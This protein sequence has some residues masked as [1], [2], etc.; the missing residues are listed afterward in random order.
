[1]NAA[2]GSSSFRAILSSGRFQYGAEVVT[3]RGWQPPGTP[4]KIAAFAADLLAEPRVGWISITDNA[5]GGPMLPPD[6]LAAHVAPE[7]HRVVIHLTCKDM[8]R[9]ALEAALW[10]YASEGFENILALTGDYPTGGFGGL[11]GPV[12]DLDSLGLITLIQAM[13]RGLVIP[14][15]SGKQETLPPTD[16]FVG[17]VVS[18]FKRHERELLPQYLKLLRKIAAGARW[19]LPQ[20]GYDMQKFHEVQL[21]LQY[22]GIDVPLVGNVYLLSRGVARMFHSGKLAGCVLTDELLETVEKYASGPDKGKKFCRELAA[23][24]LAVFKGLGF[25]AGYIGGLQK[26]EDFAELVELAESFGSDDWR[27]FIKE[28]R[29]SQPGEFYLFEHDPA[30]GLSAPDRLNQAYLASLKRPKRTR[31][32]TFNYR[33]SRFVHRLAFTRDKALYPLLKRIYEHWDRKHGLLERLAY[34]VERASK[35]MLY[36]CRDCGDCS[37]P[38]CAY[39]C[40]IRWCSKSMRNGPC[41][42]SRDGRCEVD[43]K[44]CLWARVYERLKHYGETETMLERPVVIA[45]AALKETSSWANT[46]LDRDHHAPQRHIG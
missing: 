14:G 22:H 26:V 4:G 43:D 3:S 1:M 18:P 41:G 23:K 40:P 24:Q 33:L 45:D 27:E 35:A 28:I 7:R 32:V 36:G 8:N 44:E 37:L 46:Y 15:R 39:I 20:L 13:N 34:R 17:C 9:S 10:R 12:F 38:E 29:F 21:F 16:F 42:G 11:A 25:A 2:Q 31:Y 30:T 5:G 6:W 19:V